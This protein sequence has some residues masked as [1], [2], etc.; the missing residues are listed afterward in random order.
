MLLLGFQL[1]TY[2]GKSQES[3]S[4]SLSKVKGKSQYN[5]SKVLV[6]SLTACPM[7]LEPLQ[8]TSQ[9]SSR[10]TNST[11]FPTILKNSQEIPK[12]S[13]EFLWI[14]KDLKEFFRTHINP[15]ESQGT[16]GLSDNAPV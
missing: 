15:Q 7:V 6:N 12:N 5:P 16:P 11:G 2:Y 4:K 13:K 3:H 14:P 1:G 9:G 8:V 10:G